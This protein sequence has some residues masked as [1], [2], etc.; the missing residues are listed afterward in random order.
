MISQML[1][2]VQ[3]IIQSNSGLSTEQGLVIREVIG[4]SW[5]SEKTTLDLGGMRS[6]SP[7]FVSQAIFPILIA[8][9]MDDIHEH[10]EFI[11]QPN[12]FS[13]TWDAIEKSIRVRQEREKKS[14]K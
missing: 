4:D 6:A 14:Q 2:R 8:T 1:I 12:G 3:E 5:K 13:F 11:N 10:L 9:D 7:S